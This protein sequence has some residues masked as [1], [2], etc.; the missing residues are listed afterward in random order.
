MVDTVPAFILPPAIFRR[1]DIGRL[2]RELEAQDA[3]KS[4]TPSQLLAE[5]CEINHLDSAKPTDRAKLS[6]ALEIIYTK[7]PVLHISFAA[8]PPTSM[9]VKIVTWVR[10]EIH[11]F[12]LMTVGLQPSL[13]A[14]C[15]LRT[16][17]KYFDFSLRQHLDKQRELLI[18]KLVGTTI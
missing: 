5:L 12:A 15:V 13:G 7:A 14:G 9:M 1:V 3:A 11:P 16:N 17:N 8:D 10:E 6:Q 2:Q 4:T 18:S